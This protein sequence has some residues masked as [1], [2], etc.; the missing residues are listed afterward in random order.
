MVKSGEHVGIVHIMENLKSMK[1]K[2]VAYTPDPETLIAKA[3]RS[4]RTNE[5]MDELI[6]PKPVEHYIKL[7]KST[8]H[9][10]VLEHA[11]FTFSVKDVSRVL[12]HQL[13]RHRVASYS[14]QSGRTIIYKK[15]HMII[16]KSY[17]K[18]SIWDREG[19]AEKLMKKVFK[20]YNK[21]IMDGV[22]TEDARYILPN[23]LLTNITI[24]M[25]ARELLHFFKLRLDKSAQWEIREMA[26]LMLEEVKKVAPTIFSGEKNE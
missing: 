4:C 1:V 8:G 6:L 14:Q 10:S 18:N 26:G 11:S 23:G 7:A 13:V 16:P 5:S 21:L 12:T 19:Q 25:N 17:D 2:L 15:P 22:P 20:F 3:M 24:T 9:L